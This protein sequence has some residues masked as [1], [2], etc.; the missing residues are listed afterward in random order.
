MLCTPDRAGSQRHRRLEAVMVHSYQLDL[1][2]QQSRPLRWKSPRLPA[3][4]Q[5]I[6]GCFRTSSA[7]NVV[8]TQLFAF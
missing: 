1:R 6:L 5:I 8:I 2:T 3:L 7:L 4:D